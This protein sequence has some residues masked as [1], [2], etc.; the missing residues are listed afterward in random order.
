M[1]EDD[2]VDLG[3]GVRVIPRAGGALHL[4][5]A[6]GDLG[7]ATRR[8]RVPGTGVIWD[9]RP[10]EVVGREHDEEAWR[11]IL[12]PWP[13]GEAMRQIFVLDAAAVAGA[14]GETLREAESERRRQLAALGA[15]ILGLAPA[16]LQ[17]HWRRSWGFRAGRA[18]ASSALLELVVGGVGL[19]QAFA[20]AAGSDGIL[21]PWLRWLALL[22]PVMF[23][24]SLIR[25]RLWASD[26]EPV[27]SMLGLP[28]ALVVT[29][30]PAEPSTAPEVRRWDDKAAVLELSTPVVR[31][32]WEGGGILPYKGRRL[33]L[34]S[35]S[36][37][38]RRWGYRFVAAGDDQ[39]GPLLRLARPPR[40]RIAARPAGA[41]GVVAATLV[42]A[43]MFLARS[44]QQ[45]R[46]ATRLGV[47]P[48]VL[49][50]VGGGMELVGGWVNLGRGQPGSA[51]ALLDVFFLL[52][53]GL[54]LMAAIVLRRPVGS[55]LAWPF[56]PLYERMLGVVESRSTDPGGRR[57]S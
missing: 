13:D 27:G 38:G 53:G 15:P 21:P 45:A 6:V 37:Q 22:G 12:Q 9:D 47:H 8:G 24:E 57:R 55:V 28:L 5:S 56:T 7:L 23:A 34:D 25:L 30:P 10:W 29:P 4:C 43:A 20:M 41:P 18:T 16:R 2:P 49:T 31:R 26:G 54:R 33:Q 51:W 11:F 48:I 50:M 35:V 17:L 44:D 42:T 39:D 14:A 32:D 19:V 52:E 36:R 3:H 1:S 40:P 46:W